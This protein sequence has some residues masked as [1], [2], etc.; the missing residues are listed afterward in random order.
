MC[1]NNKT[2]NIYGDGILDNRFGERVCHFLQTCCKPAQVLEEAIETKFDSKE[3]CGYRREKGIGFNIKSGKENEAQFGEFPWL[4]AILKE[5]I[6]SGKMI[7]GY[8]CAGSLIH[9]QVVLTAA[10]CV[11]DVLPNDIILRAGEWDTQIQTE[12]LKSQDIVARDV[13]VHE[14][15]YKPASLNDVALIIGKESFK[16]DGHIQTACLPPPKHNFDNNHNCLASGWGKDE[17]GKTGKF[18]VILKKVDLP[19]VPRPKCQTLLRKTRLSKHFVLHPSFICAGGIVGKDTCKGDGG[20]PLVCPIPG[21]T[22]R[23]YQAGIVAWGIGCNTE[24]PG[25]YVNVP[26][27]RDWIDMKMIAKGFDTKH[28]TP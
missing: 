28:Y 27:F 10:H 6:V 4:V 5:L 22:E 18:S 25:V 15:F 24:T 19:I 16:L 3:G 7:H 23:Y 13:I 11:F 2:V 8:K 1:A 26:L 20:A 17:F 14:D 12:P 21:S 9:P